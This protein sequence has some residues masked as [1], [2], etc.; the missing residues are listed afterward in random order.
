MKVVWRVFYFALLFGIVTL[1]ISLARPI[2]LAD[3]NIDIVRRSFCA[4]GTGDWVALSGLHSPGYS[5]NAPDFNDPVAWPECEIAHRVVYAYIPDLEIRIVDIFASNGN[6]ACR[7]V[8]EY[9]NDSKQFRTHYPD[10]IAQGSAISIYRIE[11][12][13]I[14]SEWCEYDPDLIIRFCDIYE[15]L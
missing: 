2:A 1:C 5:H 11:N 13:K 14:V 12:G 3:D 15:S 7:F 8:W 4:L 9:R 10:G 6:V